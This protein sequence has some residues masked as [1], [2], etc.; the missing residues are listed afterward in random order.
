MFGE[1]VDP[2]IRQRYAGT[3]VIGETSNYLQM[4]KEN[5]PSNPDAS[6]PISDYLRMTSAEK[7]EDIEPL[8]NTSTLPQRSNFPP[9]L[10]PQLSVTNYIN[11]STEVN[12]PPQTPLGYK[13]LGGHPP[14][15]PTE[16][17]SD[18][19]YLAMLPATQI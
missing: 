6:E 10:Y 18:T 11:T 13:N 12:T 7:R 8:S 3:E 16:S 9:K 14:L 2:I 19:N 15:S 17:L 4:N 5:A 1:M